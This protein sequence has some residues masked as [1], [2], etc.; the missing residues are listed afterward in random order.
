MY[1]MLSTGVLLWLIYGIRLGSLP[2][3]FANGVTLALTLSILALKIKY[4]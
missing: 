2:I 4:K 1:L 3:I